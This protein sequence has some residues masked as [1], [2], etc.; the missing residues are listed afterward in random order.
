MPVFQKILALVEADELRNGVGREVVDKI[1]TFDDSSFDSEQHWSNIR[2]WLIYFF[3]LR[4]V[5][6]E[7]RIVAGVQDN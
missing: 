4:A 5:T 1:Y 2:E 6:H 3:R 7:Y